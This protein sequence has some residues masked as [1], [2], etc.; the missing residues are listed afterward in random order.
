[1]TRPALLALA[2]LL[3][4]AA[5]AQTDASV[6]PDDAPGW[7][8]MEDAIATAQAED[9]L[10]VV[11]GYASWCGWCAKMDQDVY[12]DDAVQAYLSEHFTST[13]L[14]IEGEGPL[15]YFDAA[16]T[17]AQLG[18]AMGITGTPTT[19]FVAADGSLI[20]KLPGYANAETFLFALQYVREEAYETATFDQFIDAKRS[21]LSLGQ[22]TG[23]LRAPRQ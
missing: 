19:V 10:I 17:P 3:P 21:G 6:I 8:S 20:T 23:D 18:R 22:A 1:M 11:H 2:L 4:L 16:V 7:V 9:K 14:D 5:R 15:Q 12:T 13:R